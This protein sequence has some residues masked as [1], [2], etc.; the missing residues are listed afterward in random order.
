MIRGEVE[1]KVWIG[2]GGEKKR[3]GDYDKHLCSGNF[4]LK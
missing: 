1:E 4:W 3:G 2:I